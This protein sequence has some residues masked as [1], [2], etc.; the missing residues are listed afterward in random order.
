MFVFIELNRVYVLELMTLVPFRL[1]LFLFRI[2]FHHV[3]DAKDGDSGFHCGFE[4]FNFAHCGFH[5]A[6]GETVSNG[7]SDQVQAGVLKG[8][9]GWFSSVLG[10]VMEVANVSR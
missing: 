4:R 8:S 10:G 2:N 1:L 3:I 7:S 9:C 6:G 5:D